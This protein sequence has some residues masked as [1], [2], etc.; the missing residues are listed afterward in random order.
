MYRGYYA[1]PGDEPEP[2]IREDRLP[3]LRRPSVHRQVIDEADVLRRASPKDPSRNALRD[4]R[5]VASGCHRDTAPSRPG[6]A[7][8]SWQPSVTGGVQWRLERWHCNQRG[9]AAQD[10]QRE[11]LSG[12]HFT[13]REVSR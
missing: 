9:K 12:L 6:G 5:R 3:T 1:A 13:V 10:A 8:I 7:S 11:M 2:H 4:A